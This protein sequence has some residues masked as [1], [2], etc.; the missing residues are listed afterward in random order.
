MKK[1]RNII[2]AFVICA[3]L[4]LGIG[5]S[6]L[7]D[8]LTINGTVSG[9]GNDTIHDETQFDVDFTGCS[10]ESNTNKSRITAT[11]VYNAGDDEATLT[12]TGLTVKNDTVVAHYTVKIAACPEDATACT[13]DAHV[14]KD[15]DIDGIIT[16]TADVQYA[17][18]ADKLVKD[19]TATIKVTVKLDKTLLS[20]QAIDAKTFT[21]TVTATN[22]ANG[23]A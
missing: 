17:T 4:C 8:T 19:A 13:L 21:V 23:A 20:G 18:G 5:Y 3:L 11:P 22:V 12:I 6:A 16:A 15:K 14:D 1:R 9:N 7:T 2:G 10:I